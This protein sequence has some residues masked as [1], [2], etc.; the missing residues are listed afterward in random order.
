MSQVASEFLQQSSLL[1][2]QN[3]FNFLP[4]Y[5]AYATAFI[6][7]FCGIRYRDFQLDLVYPSEN[8]NQYA[9]SQIN[10]QY[11]VFKPP[12]TQTENFNV[13]GLMYRG[14]KLDIIY[15]LRAKSVEVKVEVYLKIYM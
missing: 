10:T 9:T 13:T 15:N 6:A 12:A 4:A 5:A 7:G 1:N 8:F 14:N 3:T 2:P 11:T